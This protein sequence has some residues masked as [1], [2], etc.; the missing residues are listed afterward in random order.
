MYF[1][2]LIN[3]MVDIPPIRPEVRES[4]LQLFQEN[5]Q[6]YI[7]DILKNVD[8]QYS[9][10]IHKN[11][12]QRTI[13]ALEVYY[14]TGKKYSD[15]LSL[16][17]NK[18]SINYVIIVLNIERKI[19]YDRIN[20]RVLNMIDNGLVEEV[21]K[22]L[23]LGYKKTDPGMKGIGYKEIIEYLEGSRSLDD[24]IS[25]ICKNSRR[26]AKRQLT[27]FRSVS[28]ALWVDNLDQSKAVRQIKE[29][30]SGYFEEK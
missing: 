16:S 5:G 20:Q 22:V 3:G 14:E 1:K 23:S 26:Y 17:N 10:R 7:F 15:Y 6:E 19:L 13:R 11:D 2:S 21:K 9:E 29:L 30:L 12:K 4:V 18:N 28:E 24:A 8:A 27:W 25:E